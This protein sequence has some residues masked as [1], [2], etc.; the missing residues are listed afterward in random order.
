MNEKNKVLLVDNDRS[1]CWVLDKA[2]TEE[3]FSVDTVMDGKK[4][5]EMIDENSYALII[6]D[7]M[8]PM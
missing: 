7:I 4:A 2:F 6:M 1:I 5:L 8:M 3:G